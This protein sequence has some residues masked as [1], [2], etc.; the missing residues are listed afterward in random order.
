MH[1]CFSVHFPIIYS[2]NVFNDINKDEF[3]IVIFAGTRTNTLKVVDMSECLINPKYFSVDLSL[4]L[5]GLF[6]EYFNDP[7]AQSYIY[8][9]WR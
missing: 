2:P 9:L 4:G 8:I 5:M 6:I 7:Q 3:T 1:F